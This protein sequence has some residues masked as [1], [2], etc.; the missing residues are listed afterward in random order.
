M[1]EKKTKILDRVAKLLRLAESANANE[2]ANALAQAQALLMK[3][4][5]DRAEVR[6]DDEPDDEPIVDDYVHRARRVT[7]W[8]VTVFDA[9]AK[10]NGCRILISTG[11]GIAIYGRASDIAA[12]KYLAGYYSKEVDRLVKLHATGRGRRYAT[13]FRAGAARTLHAR[14]NETRAEVRK[15]ASSAAL[16][17]VD[18]H[19][20]AVEKFTKRYSSGGSWGGGRI[21]SGDGYRDGRQ[22][23][24]DITIAGGSASLPTAPKAIG[25]VA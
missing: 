15:T 1:N 22:A 10:A 7:G 19:E 14:L 24:R 21:S 11:Y 12:V 23:G 13:A 9:L 3:H 17:R 16:V 4:D 5:L 6:L 18:A 2:A 8:R 25:G 20:N